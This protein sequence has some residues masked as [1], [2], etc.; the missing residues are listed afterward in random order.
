LSATFFETG[1]LLVAFAALFGRVALLPAAFGLFVG[2]LGMV[3]MF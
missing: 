1:V 2:L 3:F